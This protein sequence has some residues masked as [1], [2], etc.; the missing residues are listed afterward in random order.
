MPLNEALGVKMKKIKLAAIGAMI[1][2]MLFTSVVSASSEYQ[3]MLDEAYPADGPGAAVIVV[4]GDEVVFRGA[5]GMANVELGVS[6]SPD[7]VFRLAS[8]TK[9][10]TAAAILLLE[11]QDKLSVTDN[12]NKYLPN[13]PTQGHTIKIENLL[14]HTSGIFNYTNIP[15]YMGGEKIRKD[16]TTEELIEV[17]ANLPMDFA[18]GEQYRYSNS[19]YV[20][21]GAIIEKVSG[22]SYADFIQTAIFDKLGMKHSYYG[23]P[24]IIL[25]RANGYQ[26]E[27]GDYS[28]AGFLSMSQPHAAGSLLSTV[29][30]M[31]IW[32]KAL[33]GGELL[34]KKSLKK[35]DHRF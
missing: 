35:N 27:A 2:S 26:G 18:P 28:N 14:S 1:I 7:N 31:T 23:G 17:F 15:G 22:Q 4:K 12:I 30:D 11:E 8:I 24:Q 3:Q 6:L 29:D 9:Q 20:L 16:V 19:A 21:L 10:F 33:F 13:Y 5:A 25:N 32:S 34:S